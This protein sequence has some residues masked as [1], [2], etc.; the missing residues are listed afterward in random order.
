MMGRFRPPEEKSQNVIRLAD[1]LAERPATLEDM[2]D[3]NDA[4]L[5]LIRYKSLVQG[6]IIL[7]NAPGE[8]FPEILN[9]KNLTFLLDQSSLAFENAARYT[10]ARNLL[11]VDEL[12]G[13]FNYRFL[14]VA[15]E[16]EVKRAERYKTSLSV[17]FLDIDQ[18]KE[19]ND[20]HGHLVGSKVLKEVGKL[21]KKSVREI[22][23][24]IRYGGDEYTILLA[25]T[26][27]ETAAGVAERIRRSIERHRFLASDGMN[28]RITASL[29]YSC[30]P[31]DTK[32]K[33]ELI[34]FADQAMYRGKASGRNV[35]FSV[36]KARQ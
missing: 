32:S 18:F 25:E 3:L 24:V 29:G 17:I 9:L 16:R 35:V 13:L 20:T 30:Y 21:L 11:N 10:S 8:R 7:F 33:V 26:G 14:E 36:A 19:I 23:T 12:T 31:E 4:L 2:T 15:M 28:I 5:L 1:F 22:D 6:V 34:E 27:L